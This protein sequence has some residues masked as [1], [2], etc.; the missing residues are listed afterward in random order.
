MRIALFAETFLPKWDGIAHTLC[1]LLEH[2]AAAGHTSIM[3]APRGAPSVYAQTPIVGLPCFRFPLYPDLRLVPPLVHVEKQLQAFHPDLIHVVNPVSLGWVGLRHAR[4]LDL[5]VVA[6]YHTNV[7][8]YAV[9]YGLPWLRKPLWAYFRRIH[10]QADLNLCPSR[11]TRDELVAHGFE[12]IRLW[13]RGVDTQRF[14]PAHRTAEWRNYLSGGQPDAPLLLFVGRVA[15]EKRIDW[16]RPLFETLP[17]AR[18]AIVGDGPARRQIEK[19]FANTPTVFTGYLQGEAL[20]RA[21]ASADLFVFP[22]A[23]ETFGNVVLEAMA[24]GLPVVVARAGG[25]VDHVRHGENGLTFDPNDLQDMLEQVQRLVLTPGLIQTLGANARAYAETQTWTAILDGLLKDYE[26][27]IAEYK[28]R[29]HHIAA[30]RGK[31]KPRPYV[32]VPRLPG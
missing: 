5:P 6:S 12:R 24:S 7:P 30:N 25:P 32:I 19:L 26:S 29:H 10:N 21:Y 4:K 20:A 23:T 18:L 16:L 3:F 28:P 15:L 1:R 8:D 27:V 2:L 17:Q 31:S 13:G 9:R 22:S 11:F 14:H